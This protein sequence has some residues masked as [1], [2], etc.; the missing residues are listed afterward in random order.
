MQ[1]RGQSGSTPVE[2]VNIFKIKALEL[3]SSVIPDF[4]NNNHH[5]YER[6]KIEKKGIKKEG[7]KLKII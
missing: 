6:T 5:A 1:M 7:T 2:M 4:L 3:I